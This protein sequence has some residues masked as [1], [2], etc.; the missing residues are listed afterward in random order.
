MS[1]IYLLEFPENFKPEGEMKKI[2]TFED[3]EVKEDDIFMAYG[4]TSPLAVRLKY[5][6]IPYENLVIVTA[7]K[8]I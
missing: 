2:K 4:F 5:Y 3:V 7:S 6:Q 1:S 8:K